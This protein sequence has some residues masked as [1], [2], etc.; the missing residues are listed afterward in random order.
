MILLLRWRHIVALSD[1]QANESFL[2]TAVQFDMSEDVK[3]LGYKF[4]GRPA[5]YGVATFYVLV[6]AN[7]TGLGPKEDGFQ[8][9]KEASLHRQTEKTLFF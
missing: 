5:G 6:P 8:S 3:Q 2:E 1:Y 9:K 4:Y 7:A